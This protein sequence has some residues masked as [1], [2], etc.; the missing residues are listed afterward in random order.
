MVGIRTIRLYSNL[1]SLAALSSFFSLHGNVKPRTK[2]PLNTQQGALMAT[3]R[4]QHQR[5]H[6]IW[7]IPRLGLLGII[8]AS[9]SCYVLVIQHLTWQSNSP[10]LSSLQCALMQQSNKWAPNLLFNQLSWKCRQILPDRACCGNMSPADGQ[11]SQ[12]FP[13]LHA[14]SMTQWHAA[15]SW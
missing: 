10:C 13:C 15:L 8:A 12:R 11:S 5:G 2:L 1:S 14:T 4:Y 3:H 9:G 7:L 6:H